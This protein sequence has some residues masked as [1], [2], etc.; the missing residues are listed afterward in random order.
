MNMNK[1]KLNELAKDLDVSN[2]EVVECLEK[3]K[4]ETKKTMSA[5]LPDEVSYVLEYFTQKNQVENFDAFYANNV[6]PEGSAKKKAA[7]AKKDDKKSETEKA[8][9]KEAAKTE[10]TAEAEKPKTAAKKAVKKADEKTEKEINAED[11]KTAENKADKPV[12]KEEKKPERKKKEQKPAKKQEHGVK[13]Q[14]GGR[15][16]DTD[17]KGYTISSSEEPAKGRRTVDTRGN[18]VELDK[19]NEKYD[20]L[21]NTK[22][23]KSKDNNDDDDEGIDTDINSNVDGVS[24]MARTLNTKF[25]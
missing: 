1:Y 25:H 8:E 16:S 14:L 5:L 9:K 19:Y 17:D 20:N 11:K 21:A 15:S 10:K 3:Y 7:K 6:K 12:A 4:G 18:Y 2:S 24:N 22:H 13:H 23:N